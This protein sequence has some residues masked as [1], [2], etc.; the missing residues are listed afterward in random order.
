M[1]GGNGMKTSIRALCAW[2]LCF[3]VLIGLTA[4]LISPPPAYTPAGEI[5]VKSSPVHGDG[6]VSDVVDIEVP[7]AAYPCAEDGSCTLPLTVGAS[8]LPYEQDYESTETVRLTVSVV[9]MQDPF[10]ASRMTETTEPVF[11]EAFTLDG[12]STMKFNSTEP[13]PVLFGYGDF[14]PQY[15]VTSSPIIPAD[16]D[17]GR[18]T[19]VLS[20]FNADGDECCRMEVWIA[21]ERTGDS[22]C[23]SVG[24]K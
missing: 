24:K 3:A 9:P 21:F 23:L 10:R 11:T 4:C 19:A 13:E 6:G 8:H 16:V 17:R 2:L 1:K 15:H 14:Y 22:V 5:Y 20:T 18:V 12:W 7:A